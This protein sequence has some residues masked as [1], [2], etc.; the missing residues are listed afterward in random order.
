MFEDLQKRLS[1]RRGANESFSSYEPHFALH[2]AK[3]NA[4]GS[5]SALSE[6][7]SALMLLANAGVDSAH[8]NSIL[9]AASPK[10][11][12][13]T[14]KSSINEF[15]QA[16]GYETV[17]SVLRQC[18]KSTTLSCLSAGAAY[19]T[20]TGSPGI[21][22]TG[23]DTHGSSNGRPTPVKRTR[24]QIKKMENSSQYKRCG[25]YSHW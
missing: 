20:V 6:T 3:F 11:A 18:E 8:R 2:L 16:V 9:A 7:I 14:T 22:S 10:E 21:N 12:S 5:F 4:R 1:F 19:Q 24:E 13:L 23:M 17:S 15:I 25:N